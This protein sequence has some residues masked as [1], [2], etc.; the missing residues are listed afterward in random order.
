MVCFKEMDGFFLSDTEC[1]YR[2]WLGVKCPVQ[3]PPASAP[4]HQPRGGDATGSFVTKRV[5]QEGENLN[6]K[7]YPR[8][9]PKEV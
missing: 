7:L 9:K 5:A 3:H 1:F 6:P 8:E 2:I 4:L